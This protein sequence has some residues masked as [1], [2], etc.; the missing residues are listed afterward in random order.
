MSEARFLSISSDRIDILRRVVRYLLGRL[1]KIGC[2]ARVAWLLVSVPGLKIDSWSLLGL[3]AR[4]LLRTP[5]GGCLFLGRGVSIG[6]GAELTAS[7]GVVE[8]GEGTYIGP[9]TTVVA[10]QAVRIGSNCL[11]A[12]RVTIRDQDHY[13]GGAVG[14]KISESGF[15]V[16]EIEIGDDVWVGAGAVILKGVRIGRGAV[17]GANA[18]V[19]RDVG[20]GEIVGGVPARPIRSRKG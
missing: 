7:K 3:G 6:C 15:R 10:R 20:S 1:A 14:R 5:N 19:N 18:V 11:I 13:V 9:W 4:S 8:I 17:I 12:E 16:A 2:R